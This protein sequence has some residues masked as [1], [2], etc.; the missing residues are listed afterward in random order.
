MSVVVILILA[1]LGLASCFLAAFI[2]AVRSGQ[3][4]DTST[5][6]MRVLA[7]DGSGGKPIS[8]PATQPNVKTP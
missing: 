6:P 2:W 8:S 1:S 3:F 7:D 4:D 5:P